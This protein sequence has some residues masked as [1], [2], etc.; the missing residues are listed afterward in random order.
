MVMGDGT[1]AN[2]HLAYDANGNIKLM[3]QWGLKVNG[4]SVIDDLVYTYYG[5][6]NKLS[7][8][9]EQGAGATVHK[10][11]DFTDK[12][13]NGNDYGYDLNGNMVTDLNKR[14]N[15]NT[16]QTITSGGAIIYNHLN[17]PWQ[18]PVKDDNGNEKGTITYTYDA[19]GNKL[20]K[21]VEDK[22]TA[23]KIITTTTSYVGGLIYESKTTVPADAGDY[24]DQL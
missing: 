8:V 22:S 4:S 19:T 18:I 10:L 23:G 14:M 9:S 5:N 3:K 12:N 20:K 15:G 7:S 1:A 13:T 24:A 16:G 2:H 11:G 6:S 17:L 21:V